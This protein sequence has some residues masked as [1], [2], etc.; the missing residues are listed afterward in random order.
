[1]WPHAGR[2]R[3]VGI[4][5]EIL[6]YDVLL[7]L[8]HVSRTYAKAPNATS[9]QD[10]QTAGSADPNDLLSA[11]PSGNQCGLPMLSALWQEPG[12]LA[13]RR[14]PFSGCFVGSCR[15]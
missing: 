3:G 10:G 4:R 9:D 6:G 5:F 1:M 7:D 15:R 12:R 8:Q 2:R 11:L 13:G 14:T